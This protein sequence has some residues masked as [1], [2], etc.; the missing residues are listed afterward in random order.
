MNDEG[1]VKAPSSVATR[2]VARGRTSVES[3]ESIGEESGGTGKGDHGEDEV[4]AEVG[5]NASPDMLDQD[6]DK[7]PATR[8]TGFIGKNSDMQWFRRLKQ[9]ADQ[10]EDHGDARAS[11]P[12]GPPGS[13]KNASSKR[14][15][16]KRERNQ[17]PIAE[18]SSAT[19]HKD[20]DPIWIEDHIDPF[21]LPPI[22]NARKLFRFYFDTVHAGFPIIEKADVNRE[23][24]R[25]FAMEPYRL[26]HK[27]RAILNLIFAIGAKHAHLV[28]EPQGDARDHAIFFTRARMVGMNGDVLFQHPDHQQVQICAIL[29][30]YLM[31]VSQISRYV[32]RVQRSVSLAKA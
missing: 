11:A 10:G 19:Y 2:S 22:D 23:F 4:G 18:A 30:F 6:L 25:A 20:L 7:D 9:Q 24:D 21:E 29:G 16:G 1:S 13:S 26:S 27:Y 5:S 28:R 17:Q 8:A 32:D 31:S 14:D 15:E 12:Y 3:S